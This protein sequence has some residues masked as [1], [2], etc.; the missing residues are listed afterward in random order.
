MFI[1]TMPCVSVVTRTDL[2]DNGL[3]VMVHAT[4]TRSFSYSCSAIT[5]MAVSFCCS[6]VLSVFNSCT[7][8][9]GTVAELKVTIFSSVGTMHFMKL[10]IDDVP[11]S[12]GAAK[13][14]KTLNRTHM[15]LSHSD[16]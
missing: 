6:F 11:R 8:N 2:L 1:C 10:L 13:F 16:V 7:V 4:R 3:S 9:L 15:R 5:L 14:M 12:I